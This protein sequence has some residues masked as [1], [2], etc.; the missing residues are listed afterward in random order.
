MSDDELLA[1]LRDE[2]ARVNGPPTLLRRL[3]LESGAFVNLDAELAALVADSALAGA[4]AGGDLREAMSEREVTFSF[5]AGKLR[6]R[7]TRRS[8]LVG[9]LETEGPAELS[10]RAV[11]RRGPVRVEDGGSFVL[12]PLPRGPFT[13]QVVCSSG[14]RFVTDWLSG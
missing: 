10:W 9:T 12:A 6:L 7:F 1:V 8:A 14:Q 4:G 11:A 3:A 2:A 13:L 5:D